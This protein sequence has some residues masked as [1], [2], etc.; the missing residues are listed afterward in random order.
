[1]SDAAG[2][3]QPGAGAACAAAGGQVLQDGLCRDMAADSGHAD[4]TAEYSTVLDLKY[5]DE[6]RTNIA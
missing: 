1:M 3:G 5:D 2:D 4:K 6:V